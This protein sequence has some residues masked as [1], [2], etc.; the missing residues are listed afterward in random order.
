MSVRQETSGTPGALSGILFIV[1]LILLGAI[2]LSAIL[3]VP[4][5]AKW[6][7]VQ[8]AFRPEIVLPVLL[9]AGV[10]ALVAV[11]TILVLLLSQLGLSNGSEALGLPSGSI[12]A[13]LALLLLLLFAVIAIYLYGDLAQRGQPTVSRGLSTEEV[14]VLPAAQ[15]QSINARQE[16]K[17]RVFDVVLEGGAGQDSRDL[18]NQI[19]TTAA[20]LAVAIVGFYFGTKSL[21]SATQSIVA[22][23]PTGVTPILR[24][25]SPTSPQILDTAPGT[26]LL[27]PIRIEVVPLGAA[28]QW[29]VVGDGPESLVQTARNTFS[30]TR[31][32]NAASTVALIFSLVDYPTVSDTLEVKAPTP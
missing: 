32:A 20:T 5:A 18:A 9:I 12:S 30:Y 23:R 25:S 26:R 19:V 15:I 2:A 10:I 27:E 11:I 4:I 17:E 13:V 7:R 8:R 24:I 22:T 31:G 21:A 29:R 28:T 6:L 16:G 1:S 3:V 14:Q